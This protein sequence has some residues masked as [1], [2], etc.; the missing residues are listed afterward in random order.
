MVFIIKKGGI[1]KMDISLF[2]KSP[3]GAE[4]LSAVE[5]FNLWDMLRARYISIE[6]YQLK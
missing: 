2:K 6:T 5:G 4:R 3:T 1:R